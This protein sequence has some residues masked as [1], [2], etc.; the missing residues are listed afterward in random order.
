MATFIDSPH[1]RSALFVP[2]GSGEFVSED[3]PLAAKEIIKG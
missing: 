3:F 1:I 2:I